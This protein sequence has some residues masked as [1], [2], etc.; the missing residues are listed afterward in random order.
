V[1][2]FLLLLLL[3]T[4]FSSQDC[5]PGKKD[6][7][8]ITGESGPTGITGITEEE[9]PFALRYAINSVK[10]GNIDFFISTLSHYHE[11]PEDSPLIDEIINS[12]KIAFMAELL[13]NGFIPTEITIDKVIKERRFSM[14]TDI[15]NRGQ[16]IENILLSIQSKD[17]MTYVNSKNQ[18]PGLTMDEIYLDKTFMKSFALNMIKYDSCET[19]ESLQHYGLIF[20]RDIYMEAKRLNRCLEFF[21][22]NF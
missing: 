5:S 22:I 16:S 7:I 8:G 20:E 2:L 18:L 10:T 4:D 12:N 3:L 17:Y 19:L 11:I 14:L 6:P 1:K 9:N 15:L 13:N 21:G